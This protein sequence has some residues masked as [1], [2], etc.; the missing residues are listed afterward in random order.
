MEVFENKGFNPTELQ[1]INHYQMYLQVLMLS[2]IMTV[3]GNLFT[4]LTK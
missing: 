4:V 3:N 1:K 2:D